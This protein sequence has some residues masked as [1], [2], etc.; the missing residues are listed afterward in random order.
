MVAR[1]LGV[2]PRHGRR[3]LSSFG[4]LSTFRND[5]VIIMNKIVTLVVYLCRL[6]RL[7]STPSTKYDT[8]NDVAIS[9][10]GWLNEIFAAN[11]PA[12]Q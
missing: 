5:V 2:S 8:T 11:H 3:G 1:P 6:T 12:A 7:F 4:R 9:V 10:A